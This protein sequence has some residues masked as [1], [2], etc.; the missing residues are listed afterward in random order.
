MNI[1]NQ[2]INILNKSELSQEDADSLSCQ[3]DLH[4]MEDLTQL[5]DLVK[6]M[7]YIVE[8]VGQSDYMI[9]FM[10]DFE[11]QFKTWCI[12]YPVTDVFRQ[13]LLMAMNQNSRILVEE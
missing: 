4:N 9:S 7:P 3:A 2:T 8:T 13:H 1:T 10:T 11:K 5:S 12:D 6:S